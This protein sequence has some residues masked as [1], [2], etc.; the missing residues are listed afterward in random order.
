LEHRYLKLHEVFWPGPSDDYGGVTPQAVAALK[1]SLAVS[2]YRRDFEA[3]ALRLLKLV[4][5]SLIYLCLAV[6][7]EEEK[8]SNE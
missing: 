4:R 7:R 2:R 8:R 1:D 5:A 3:K 6:H